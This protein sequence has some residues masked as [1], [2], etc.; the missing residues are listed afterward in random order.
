MKTIISF[1]VCLCT[2]F[3]AMAFTADTTLR[4]K[5]KHLTGNFYVHISYGKY[6]GGVVAANGLYV[7][8]PDGIVLIDTPWSE[9]QTKQLV[10]TLEKRHHKK[11]ILC[12]ASH[13]HADRTAG[14]DYLKKLG[15]KTYTSQLTQE[16]CK[17]NQEPQ[18]QY[19]FDKDTTFRVK[20]LELQTYY[21]GEGHTR[22]NIVVWFP[23]AKVLYGGCLVKSM[24]ATNIGFTGDGN[25]QAYP[26][27]L[28]KLR[29]KFPHPAYLIP[30]HEGWQ[31]GIN[32]VQHTLEL[33]K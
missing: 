20:G 13:F 30:G 26:A 11:I 15:V 9:D 16:L 6:Q 5:T 25:L 18:A 24:D 2:A 7:I 1:I 10:D 33:L 29:D 31:G 23:K 28:R 21:P 19:V 27:T 14:L 3:S 22:D 17:L 32:Q 4:I 8:T 12:I